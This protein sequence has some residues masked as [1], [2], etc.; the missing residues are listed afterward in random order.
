[1]DVAA[2][3]KKYKDYI[4]KLIVQITP[5]LPSDINKLQEDYLISNLRHSCQLL[6]LS[7][8]TDSVFKTLD[9]GKQHIYIQIMKWF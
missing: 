2:V 5:L 3:D 4:E 1:M 9:E 6:A 8:Q 7:M